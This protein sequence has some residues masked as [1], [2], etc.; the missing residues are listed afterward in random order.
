MVGRGIF[1]FCFLCFGKEEDFSVLPACFIIQ[2]SPMLCRVV[3][4]YNMLNVSLILLIFY[5]LYLIYNMDI[6]VA[7]M[8]YIFRDVRIS[9]IRKDQIVVKVPFPK[10][11][12]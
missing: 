12:A 6:L 5:G 10:P 2:L 7:V 4:S 11:K 3:I 1:L 8:G 9:C